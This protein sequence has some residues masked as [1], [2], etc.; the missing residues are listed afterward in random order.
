MSHA[1]RVEPPVGAFFGD[2]QGAGPLGLGK[3]DLATSAGRTG[4]GRMAEG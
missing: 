3:E 4:F 1:R 2:V